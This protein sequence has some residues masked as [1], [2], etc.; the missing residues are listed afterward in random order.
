MTLYG[1]EVVPASIGFLAVAA[2]GLMVRLYYNILKALLERIKHSEA[3]ADEAV[4]MSAKAYHDAMKVVERNGE[5]IEDRGADRVRIAKL[6]NGRA[7]DRITIQTLETAGI[8]LAERLAI[9]ERK[10]DDY[11]RTHKP[12]PRKRKS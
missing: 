3:R 4:G 9:C 11:D 1:V 10:W 7:D 5:L 6:E 8:N 12:P 2:F